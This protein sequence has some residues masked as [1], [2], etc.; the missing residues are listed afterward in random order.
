MACI[1][2]VSHSCASTSLSVLLD[3]GIGE[4][5]IQLFNALFLCMIFY[6]QAIGIGLQTHCSHSL[7]IIDIIYSFLH[8]WLANEFKS[9]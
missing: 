9:M 4:H 3:L 8:C 6:F 2:Y 5:S 7:I 1:R